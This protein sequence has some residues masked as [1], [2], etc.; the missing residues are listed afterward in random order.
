[1]K[2]VKEVKIENVFNESKMKLV[3]DF[4]KLKSK[5]QTKERLLRN[6]LLSIQFKIE[7]YIE[8]ENDDN[9]KL[10]DFIKMYLRTL[11]ITKK[12]FAKYLDMH[13][14]NLHKYLIGE[15]RLNPKV[16]LKISKFTHTEPEVWYRIQIKNEI[17]ELRKEE[18][19]T[20]EYDKYDYSKVLD[21]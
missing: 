4:I 18:R 12:D 1:M 8:K 21:L 17:T 2:T 7:D 14:S 16:A 11:N 20:N 15:R 3:K 13:D 6:E 5:E 10:L 19:K 9:L